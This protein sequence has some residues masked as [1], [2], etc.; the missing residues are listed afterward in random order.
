MSNNKHLQSFLRESKDIREIYFPYD[1]AFLYFSE[2][3]PYCVI[4]SSMEKDEVLVK[5]AIEDQAL[6][7]IPLKI[8]NNK[9][10][11]SKVVLNTLFNPNSSFLKID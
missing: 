11:M 9:E 6:F 4:S 3:N 10:E 1:S 8:E 7:R 2:S 5:Y